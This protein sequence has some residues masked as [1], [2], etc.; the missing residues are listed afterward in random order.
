MFSI[1]GKIE[2]KD[3]FKYLARKFTHNVL[4]QEIKRHRNTPDALIFSSKHKPKIKEHIKKYMSR[5]GRVYKAAGSG[6]S[7]AREEECRKN[8]VED[9][10]LDDEEDDEEEED[11]GEDENDEDMEREQKRSAALHR[12]GG[13]NGDAVNL[14]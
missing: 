3:D 5:F 10:D 1:Q 2:S 4:E 14:V 6:E 11:G 12:S 8:L 7:R 13:I 9:D